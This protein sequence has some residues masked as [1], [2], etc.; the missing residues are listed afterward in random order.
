MVKEKLGNIWLHQ[1][2]TKIVVPTWKSSEFNLIDGGDRGV[3]ANNPTLV[4]IGE[5]TK[6]IYHENSDF[7]PDDILSSQVSYVDIATTKSLRNLVKVGE[8]S[9]KKASFEGEL[10]DQYI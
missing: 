5:V 3:A 10:R 4:S 8:R 2:L 9:L 1:T 7:F 6:E